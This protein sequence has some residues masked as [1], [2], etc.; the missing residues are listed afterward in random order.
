MASS[1]KYYQHLRS[2]I[3]SLIPTDLQIMSFREIL[4]ED[5]CFVAEGIAKPCTLREL[6][7][8]VNFMIK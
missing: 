2:M 8:L 3:R 7:N 6:T 5:L 4:K 1:E